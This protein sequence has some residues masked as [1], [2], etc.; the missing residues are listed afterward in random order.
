[1]KPVCTASLARSQHRS[2]QL[3]YD[4]R[5]AAIPNAEE[6]ECLG[7][8]LL[9]TKI[10]NENDLRKSV[11]VHVYIARYN[12]VNIKEEPQLPLAIKY[13]HVHYM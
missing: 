7:K 4:L 13:A 1:M 2:I 11:S 12:T 6:K 3:Q 8:N 10:R 9:E 5:V